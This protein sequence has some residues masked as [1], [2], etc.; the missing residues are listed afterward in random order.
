MS[1]GTLPCPCDTGDVPWQIP[2]SSSSSGTW[3]NPGQVP[4]S[5]RDLG[6]ARAGLCVPLRLGSPQASAPCPHRHPGACPHGHPGTSPLV[7]TSPGLALTSAFL[8]LALRLFMVAPAAA[9]WHLDRAQPRPRVS[10]PPV[11]ALPAPALL[12]PEPRPRL[13]CP[14]SPGTRREGHPRRGSWVTARLRLQLAALGSRG[15]SQGISSVWGGRQLAP[16]QCPGTGGRG[17]A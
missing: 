7:P 13:P 17:G 5:L 11:L 3:V 6:H 2:M 14:H 8:N 10:L 15:G 12:L 1:Q 4:T 9:P 16:L